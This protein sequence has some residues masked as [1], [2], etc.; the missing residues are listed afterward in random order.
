MRKPVWSRFEVRLLEG[1]GEMGETGE[2]SE[3]GEDC[4]LFRGRTPAFKWNRIKIGTESKF[5]NSPRS[6]P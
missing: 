5:S 2:T 3:T 4:E 6:N 1:Q